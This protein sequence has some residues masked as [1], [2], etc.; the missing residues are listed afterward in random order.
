MPFRFGSIVIKSAAVNKVRTHVFTYATSRESHW[1]AWRLCTVEVRYAGVVEPVH[2][3]N[4]DPLG[5]FVPDGRE[6]RSPGAQEPP[7]EIQVDSIRL[8]RFRRAWSR[9]RI[10]PLRRAWVGG[11][12][13]GGVGMGWGWGCLRQ[14][15]CG[16]CAG[17]GSLGDLSLT[18]SR[19]SWTALAEFSFDGGKSTC[20]TNPS[21]PNWTAADPR[22]VLE[23]PTN[24][25]P[26]STT[27]SSVP[28][29]FDPA[30]FCST[31]A[32]AISFE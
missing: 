12:D 15:L 32:F 30:R 21:E 5:K 6:P 1:L 20:T 17:F 2:V 16:S 26:R 25:S 18:A 7:G 3:R 27:A 10:D 31:N 24:P 19:A 28:R 11:V 22:P 9:G 23:N 13:R 4:N 8:L 14:G 29:A